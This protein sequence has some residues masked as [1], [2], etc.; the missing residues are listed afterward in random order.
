MGFWW[1]V[2]A[3]R[4]APLGPVLGLFA[5]ETLFGARFD[6]CTGLGEFLQTL[7]APRQ[8]VGNLAQPE[9]AVNDV[10]QGNFSR[11]WNTTERFGVNTTVGGAGVFDVA[12]GWDLPGHPADFGQT[13]GVWGVDSGPA[14]QLPLLGPTNARDAVGTVVGSAMNP[15]GFAGGGAASAVTT[16][17]AGLGVVDGRA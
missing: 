16:V 9:I 4:A 15:L 17:G 5:L 3:S 11:A 13:L 6:L 8:F 2:L 12:S 14:V 7:L 10:L 1:L